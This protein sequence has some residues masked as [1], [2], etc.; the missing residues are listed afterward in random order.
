[1]NLIKKHPLAFFVLALIVLRIPMIWWYPAPLTDELFI[2]DQSFFGP[3]R[4]L[5]MLPSLI[6]MATWVGFGNWM[7]GKFIAMVM[8]VLTVI[9]IFYMTRRIEPDPRAAWLAAGLTAI[10][11][12]VV[13]WS[14]RCMTDVPFTLFLTASIASA[15]YWVYEPKTRNLGA[16]MGFAGLAMLTR[17]EGLFMIPLIPGVLLAHMIRLRGEGFVPALKS[18]AFSLWGLIPWG[19]WVYWRLVVNAKDAYTGTFSKNLK[20]IS[21][22]YLGEMAAHF[23]SYTITGFY[24]LGPVICL[25]VLAYAASLAEKPNKDRFWTG[26]G[27][28]YVILATTFISCVHWFFSIRHMVFMF[29]AMISLAVVGLWHYHTRFPRTIKVLFVAQFLLS[30][31][32]LCVGLWVTKDSFLDIKVAATAARADGFKGTV[33]ATDF[34]QRKTEFFSGGNAIPYNA[35]HKFKAGERIL[36][37]SFML[38]PKGVDRHLSSLKRRYKIRVIADATSRQGQFMA[39]DIAESVR[40]NGNYRIIMNRLF[41][42]QNFRTVVVEIEGT[43]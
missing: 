32:V 34:K 28:L 12:L 37:D 26:M 24:I 23:G 42:W 25:G 39:D 38:S 17:P 35:K 27:V 21:L 22:D 9:P 6:D 1:M 10:S 4:R 15:V 33:R 8:G 18:A 43:K 29:P 31:L 14:L 40:E 20:R 11:P 13:R 5:P 19:L 36:L 3:G 41:K 16:F 7:S 2:I 30:A